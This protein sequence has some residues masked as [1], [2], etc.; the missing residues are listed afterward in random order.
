[1]KTKQSSLSRWWTVVIFAIAMAWV[2]SAVVFYLRTMIHRI[3]PF[4]L[5]PLPVIGN[6]GPVELVREA[7]TMIMLLTAGMLAGRTWRSRLGYSALAFGVWDIFYYIFLKLICGWPD[8][9]L[10]WDVLFLLP[11]PWWGPVLAPMS[12]AVLMVAWGTLTQFEQTK[13]VPRLG[14]KSWALGALGIMLSLY[15]FMEDAIRVADQGADAI[16]NVLPSEFNWPLFSVALLLMSAPLIRLCVE[17]WPGAT[18]GPES[19]AAQFA[20]DEA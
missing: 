3:D 14:I 18:G 12:I 2:E 9:L 17:L 7:A 20:P 5:D 6:L 10:D 1:M 19:N 11:L 15:V 4:Q 8:S 16:R 13:P